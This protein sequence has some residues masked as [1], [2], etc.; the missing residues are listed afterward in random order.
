LTDVT[1][2]RRLEAARLQAVEEARAQQELAIGTFYHIQLMIDMICHELRN[3][4]NGIYHNG[5]LVY[6]SILQTRDKTLLLRQLLIHS[7]DSEQETAVS[8]F[9][10]HLEAELT[11]DLE[12]MEALSQCAKHQNR[13]ADDVLQLGKL[14]MNLVSIKELPFDPLIQVRKSMRMFEK[15]VLAKK[16]EVTL[17]VRAGYKI[18]KVGWVYGDPI[19]FAQVLI[20]LLSNAV[21]FTEQTPSRTVEIALDASAESTVAK[22]LDDQERGIEHPPSGDFNKRSIFLICSVIDSGVGL[23]KED[24]ARLMKQLGQSSPKTH[25]EYDGNGLGLFI[26]KTIVEAHG[27]KLSVESEQGRG[28]K[29]TFDISVKLV[30]PPAAPSRNINADGSIA[31]STLLPG[32]DSPSVSLFDRKVINIL[33]VEDNLVMSN[34]PRL[35]LLDQP[36]SLV[37]TVTPGGI[38]IRSSQSRSRVSRRPEARVEGKQ[39]V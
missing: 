18:L 21:R 24:Q 28:T 23:T 33:V 14:S 39:V 20:N 15:E 16:I 37:A 7:K 22:S 1:E 12:S 35:T 29:V 30:G 11:R 34:T 31:S 10:E 2:R 3:P 17:S 9:L 13:I 36:K 8:H 6:E 4:L 25:I 5:E 32:R 26:S 27:G 38:S 19:R